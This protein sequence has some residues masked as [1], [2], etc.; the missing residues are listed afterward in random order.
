MRAVRIAMVGTGRM[1]RAHSQAY[2]TA[3][4]FFDLPVRPHLKVVCGRSVERAEPLAQAFE[5]EEAAGDWRQVVGRD[6]VDLVDVV[7][8]T[9]LHCDVVRA[10]AEAGKAVVCEKPLAVDGAQALRALDAVTRARVPSAV[11]FNY[12][13]VPAVRL[14]HD[15]LHEGRLGDVRHFSARF[16]QDWLS[17]PARPMSWRLRRSEGGGVLLDLGVHLVDLV[18]HLIG[19]IDAVAASSRGFVSQREDP[20]GVVHGV[21]VED[22]AAAL[23]EVGGGATGTLQVSRLAA[24]NRCASGFE[25]TGSRGAVRWD[26][27]SMNDL[28]VYLPDESPLLEGWRRVSV[29]RPGA[30]PWAQAWWGGG[31][32]IGFEE[33]FVHELAAFLRRLAGETDEVPAVEDGVRAQLVLDGIQTA[34]RE[35]RWVSVG[36]P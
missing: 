31:H 18:R 6:D 5:W 19:E 15:L 35:R 7:A 2:L 24:G 26:F 17:D 8:P 12:R 36:R 16:L 30:H 21:D 23:L 32:P 29:T 13:Y 14:A 4:R 22:A 11:I 34:A 27:Q 3:A 9:A 28:D 1:A 33:T 10:A 20:T 25:I